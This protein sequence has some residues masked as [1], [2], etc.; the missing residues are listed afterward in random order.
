MHI[1]FIH[2]GETTK[3]TEN[4][5]GVTDDH[6]TPRERE[7]SEV[8]AEKLKDKDIEA[9]FS[10]T[11][12]R[13]KETAE[14]LSKKINCPVILKQHLKEKVQFP[15]AEPSEAFRMRIQSVLREIILDVRYDCVAAV[16]QEGAMRVL[17]R[18]VL[19]KGEIAGNIA[20][21]GFVEI[22][23]TSEGLKIRSME[24]ITLANGD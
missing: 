7:Q 22:E 21:C 12:I 23:K 11:L 5:H 6:L 15:E 9:I 4:R 19:K 14:I 24:G 10:S 1:F 3:N 8:L 20:D 17:F 2:Y 13:P 16:I 18:D